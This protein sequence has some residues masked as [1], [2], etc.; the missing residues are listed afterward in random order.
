MGQIGTLAINGDLSLNAHSTLNFDLSGSNAD[1]LTV[2]GGLSVSGVANVALSALSLTNTS[3]PYILATVSG[4]GLS[5]SEFQ[6]TGVPNLYQF[7]VNANDLELDYTGVSSGPAV[8]TGGNGV[9]SLAGS[10]SSGS[11]PNGAGTAAIVGAGFSDAASQTPV[12]VTFDQP[13]TLGTLT[14]G[15]SNATKGT[16]YVLTAA[17]SSDVLTMDNSGGTASIL[18]TNASHTISVPVKIATHLSIVPAAS[19]ATFDRRAVWRDRRRQRQ[20]HLV[21]G[22]AGHAGAHGQQHLWRRHAGQRGHAGGGDDGGDSQRH[23]LDGGGRRDVPLRPG[24]FARRVARGGRGGHNGRGAGAG[25]AGACGR[26]PGGGGRLAAEGEEVGDRRSERRRPE[27]AQ[28]SS[29]SVEA[30]RAFRS[31]GLKS[32]LHQ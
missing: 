30:A 14:L 4:G 17:T 21:A 22:W 15:N 28:R 6:A 2:S 25:H 32:T 26:G 31:A 3:T 27:Q 8:W 11:V 7:V 5:A 24:L 20:G 1:T 12:T 29:G 18:V 9:W 10:W 19:T 13:V 23:E 16:G